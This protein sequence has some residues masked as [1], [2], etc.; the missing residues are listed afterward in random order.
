[1]RARRLTPT[2][3]NR[4]RHTIHLLPQKLSW[5]AK[6][7]R[8]AAAFSSLAAMCDPRIARTRLPSPINKTEKRQNRLHDSSTRFMAYDLRRLHTPSQRHTS[9]AHLLLAGNRMFSSR[10]DRVAVSAA[11]FVFFSLS[12]LFIYISRSLHESIE[13]SCCCCVRLWIACDVTE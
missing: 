9:E 13:A 11:Q 6:S 3:S 2:Y 10:R 1:M 5:R 7:D 4:T 12:L 8:T